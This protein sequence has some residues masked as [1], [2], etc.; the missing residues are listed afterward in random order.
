MFKVSVN[1]DPELQ[2]IFRDCE[3]RQIHIG[4]T[5]LYTYAVEFHPTVHNKLGE[6]TRD[7]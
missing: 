1:V 3:E 2:P 6:S 4:N 7:K 5:L